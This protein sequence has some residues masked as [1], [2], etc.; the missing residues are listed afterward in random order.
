MGLAA[1]R[2]SARR[3]SRC[4]RRRRPSPSRPAWRCWAAAPRPCWA[5]P[6]GGTRPAPPE[7][8]PARRRRR[9][10]FR[11]VPPSEGDLIVKTT[12]TPLALAVALLAGPAPAARAGF[13]LQPAGAST[14]MG[15]IVGTSS[16]DN[17]RNQS[18]L[19]AGYTSLVTDFDSYIASNPT[20]N[21][22]RDE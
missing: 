5:T 9:S 18:G 16:P 6:G 1:I 14:N 20:H 3:R 10:V 13:V 17:T 22:Q 2:P 4:S 21:N 15:S 19:S 11:P 8:H 12:L 7:R